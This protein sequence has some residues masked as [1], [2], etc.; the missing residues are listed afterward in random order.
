MIIKISFQGF[1]I[2][3]Y[4]FKLVRPKLVDN[5]YQTNSIRHQLGGKFH[6]EIDYVLFIFPNNRHKS[7]VKIMQRAKD[8]ETI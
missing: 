3:I 2:H 8:F 5:G 7:E 6:F 1:Y 4:R